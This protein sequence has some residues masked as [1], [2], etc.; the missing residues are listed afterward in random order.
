MVK[1]ASS[2]SSSKE[3]FT[4]HSGVAKEYG[5]DRYYRQNE[6]RDRWLAEHKHNEM[7][8]KSLAHVSKFSYDPVDYVRFLVKEPFKE[9]PRQEFQA[10]LPERLMAAEKR[11]RRP[12]M[13]Q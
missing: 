7:I 12:I 6:Q 8:E 2:G 1:N 3:Q 5:N 4:I 13:Q 9:P 11:Y 10:L